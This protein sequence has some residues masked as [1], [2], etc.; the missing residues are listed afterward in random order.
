MQFSK[1]FNDDSISAWL[2]STFGFPEISIGPGKFSIS[3][4]SNPNN[5]QMTLSLPYIERVILKSETNLRFKNNW[6]SYDTSGFGTTFLPKSNIQRSINLRIYDAAEL[7]ESIDSQQINTGVSLGLENVEYTVLS[8]FKGSQAS[9]MS[10]RVTLNGNELAMFIEIQN[11][12]DALV[13]FKFGKVIAKQLDVLAKNDTQKALNIERSKFEFSISE[14]KQS[15][16]TKTSSQNVLEF[17]LS[18]MGFEMVSFTASD[19]E[20]IIDEALSN[21]PDVDGVLFDAGINE[22]AKEWSHGDIE[23]IAFKG[24]YSNSEILQIYYGNWLRD[25][26]S[27]ITGS[28]VGFDKPDRDKLIDLNPRPKAVTNYMSDFFSKPSQDSWVKIITLLAANEF[29]YKKSPNNH[30]ILDHVRTLSKTYDTPTKNIVGLYRP[31]EHIDNPKA[32]MDESSLSSSTLDSPV[33]YTYSKISTSGGPVEYV[34]KQLYIGE[35]LDSLK[36]TSKMKKYIKNTVSND[37]RPSSYRY[38]GEQMRLAKKKGKN[39]TG[40]RHFGAAL[41]VLE[42]FYAHSNFVEV[43]LIKLGHKKVYPWVDLYIDGTTIPSSNIDACKIP[44]VTGYFGQLDIIASLAPKIAQDF[45]PTSYQAYKQLNPGDRTLMDEL[46]IIV[47]DDYI[48]KEEGMKDSEKFSFLTFGYKEMKANY[49]DYLKILDLIRKA[50]QLPFIGSTITTYKK[51]LDIL[52]QTISFLPNLVISSILNSL[53]DAVQS[54]QTQTGTIG[55]NPSHT[56]LAKDH[57]D[58]HFNDLAGYLAH[59]VVK[60]VG[61]LMKK[62]WKGDKSVTIESII[63]LVGERYFV[64]PC[65]VD[66]IDNHIKEWAGKNSSKVKRGESKTLYEHGTKEFN[67]LKKDV[68]NKLKEY[69]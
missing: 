14:I 32:L 9:L 58:H 53:D 68:D 2:T 5:L 11:N 29:V 1:S 47:L 34:T 27:V 26:S 23:K 66:W 62:C 31:E 24:I 51:T 18:T 63:D 22:N 28:T 37:T 19:F 17:S 35:S 15:L 39:K 38:F 41:H 16:K 40:F 12:Q 6:S 57:A 20:K 52:S 8:F 30:N 69:S 44:V 13:F 54:R 64:H 4:F 61:E 43:A 60:R 46:I 3:T 33:N 59:I 21:I 65:D 49:L 67:K 50:E 10:D 42:D 7:V 48:G 45:F 36:I 55:T 56:Q 25:Y